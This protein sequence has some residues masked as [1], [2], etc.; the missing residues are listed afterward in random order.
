[1][2]TG[3]SS[4]IPNSGVGRRKSFLSPKRNWILQIW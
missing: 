3:A 1:L 4:L 2:S